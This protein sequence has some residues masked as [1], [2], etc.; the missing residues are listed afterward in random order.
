MCHPAIPAALAAISA[1]QQSQ[2]AK[3][4][5][6]YNAVVSENNATMAEYQAADAFSRGE[7]DAITARRKAAS[8]RGDQRAAM[9]AR[10]LD[11]GEGTAANLI[12]QTDYFSETDQ[13]TIRSNAGKEVF[14]KRSQANNFKTEATMYR[15]AASAQNPLLSAATAAATTYATTSMLGKADAPGVADKWNFWGNS[16]NPGGTGIKATPA[17]M[18]GR[19]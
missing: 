10:G 8:V 12:D 1:Y 3:T 2:A 14:A 16:S 17:S 5:A 6:E 4:Q 18:W 9:A 7:Q 19:G 11:L 15:S 13:G